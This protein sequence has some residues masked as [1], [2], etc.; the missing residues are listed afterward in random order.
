M[1]DPFD[2]FRVS[3][4]PSIGPFRG[5]ALLSRFHSFSELLRLSEAELRAVDGINTRLATRLQQALSAEKRS[6]DIERATESSRVLCERHEILFLPF[7]DPDY[8]AL[9]RGIYDPPLFLFCRG[10]IED[11]DL[12]SIAVVGTRNPSDYGRQVTEH[13]CT[14]FSAAGVTVVS[15]LAMGIDTVAHRST[16]RAGGRTIAVLGSGVLNIYPGVNRGL[17]DT[18]VEHG[19]VLSELPLKAKPDATNFPRRNRI[20]SGLSRCLLVTES[21]VRGGAMISAHIA[22][23][24]NRDLYAVPGSVFNP[25]SAGPHRLL[26]DSMGQIAVSPE[27]I[28]EE[29]RPLSGTSL[30]TLQPPP[31]LTLEEEHIMQYLSND[32]RHIDDLAFE[33][34]ETLPSLLVKLLQMELN[35]IVRQLPG[36]YFIRSNH[37]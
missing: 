8:P 14:Q 19:C 28:L 5:R 22:L 9:L 6:G 30:P 16:L 32:P 20:I 7:P 12:R 21:D 3:L 34:E 13:F 33:C 25:R 35:G 10:K 15:G 4:L 17:S 2:Y 11:A 23:D 29:V 1:N 31:Q 27:Q 26:R 36:K 24:Q 18:I 37:C